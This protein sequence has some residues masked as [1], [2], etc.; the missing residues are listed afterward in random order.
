VRV[1]RLTEV[2]Q[3]TGL[4]KTT[5]YQ[6]QSVGKFPRPVK[7]TAQAVGWIGA[8]V[9]VPGRAPKE[10]FGTAIP[11]RTTTGLSAVR[12]AEQAPSVVSAPTA[13]QLPAIRPAGAEVRCRRTATHDFYPQSKL[14]ASNFD[15]G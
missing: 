11:K 5:I 13:I 7:M 14:L 6:L 4:G 8:R 10:A 3:I 9:V 2:I 12:T 1:L 15:C